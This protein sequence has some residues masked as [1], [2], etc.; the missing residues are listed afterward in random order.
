[1]APERQAESN[2]AHPGPQMGPVQARLPESQDDGQRRQDVPNPLKLRAHPPLRSTLRS[3]RGRGTANF[4]SK[5]I[6]RPIYR[7]TLEWIK[8]IKRN[9]LPPSPTCDASQNETKLSPTQAMDGQDS[10]FPIRGSGTSVTVPPRDPIKSF[11]RL[12]LP[13]FAVLDGRGKL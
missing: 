13:P 6:L 8:F 3:T 11:Y 5:P 2:H 7:P 1:M 10:G 9:L 12:D 4:E